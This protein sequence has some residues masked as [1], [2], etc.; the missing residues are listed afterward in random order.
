MDAHL[1]SG[2]RLTSNEVPLIPS[3][4][5]PPTPIQLLAVMQVT[6]TDISLSWMGMTARR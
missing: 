1:V 2:Q 4:F 6:D 3:A 5:P